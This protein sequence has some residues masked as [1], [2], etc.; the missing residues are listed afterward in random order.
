MLCLNLA[1]GRTLHFDLSE[2][3]Q[4]D[5]W[6]SL[7]ADPH[8]QRKVTGIG[9]LH[10]G[11]THVLPMPRRFRAINYQAELVCKE[12]GIAVAERITCQADDVEFSM[13]VYLNGS[14]PLARLNLVKTGKLRFPPLRRN[15]GK[16]R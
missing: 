4:S 11:Y 5:R 8:F 1:D 12:D 9:I 10:G 13:L 7:Q 2:Q 6:Q 14:S 15:G 16:E 3:Q